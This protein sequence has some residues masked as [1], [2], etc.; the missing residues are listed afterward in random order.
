MRLLSAVSIALLVVGGSAYA[1][2]ADMTKLEE[3][4]TTGRPRQQ[5]DLDTVKLASAHREQAQSIDEKTDGLFQ[6]WLVSICQGCGVDVQP[7]A[8]AERAEDAPRRSVPM[9]TGAVDPG[10]GKPEGAKPAA[11]PDRRSAHTTVAADL[12]PGTVSALRR[13]PRQ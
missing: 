5:G 13:M 6:S 12:S 1:Q 11:A 8:R 9:T 3:L 4:R 10:A 2:D 7:R